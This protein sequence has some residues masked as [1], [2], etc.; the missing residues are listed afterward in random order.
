MRDV[1]SFDGEDVQ[2]SILICFPVARLLKDERTD[3]QNV[4]D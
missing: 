4:D 1:R 2:D 3:L